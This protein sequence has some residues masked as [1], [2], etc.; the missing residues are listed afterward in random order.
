M[1]GRFEQE[2]FQKNKYLLEFNFGMIISSMIK[3]TYINQVFK[4]ISNWLKN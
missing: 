1:D 4:N 2:T 3:D